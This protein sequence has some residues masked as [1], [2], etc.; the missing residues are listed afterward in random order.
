MKP[1][2]RANGQKCLH[3]I[4]RIRRASTMNSRA[5]RQQVSFAAA[6]VIKHLPYPDAC[7]PGFRGSHPKEGRLPKSKVR[8][9]EQISCLHRATLDGSGAVIGRRNHCPQPLGPP[10]PRV[11]RPVRANVSRGWPCRRGLVDDNCKTFS[12]CCPVTSASTAFPF[13]SLHL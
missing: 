8:G 3:R 11:T 7:V 13:S 9:E 2:P 10:M 1:T 5:T 4:G 12:N 6:R